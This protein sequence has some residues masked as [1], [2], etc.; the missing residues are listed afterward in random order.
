MRVCLSKSSRNGWPGD[1]GFVSHGLVEEKG[2][3]DML[4]R[5]RVK[6]RDSFSVQKPSVFDLGV[7]LQVG[8]HHIKREFERT[9]I[10][11]SE[12]RRDVG[13]VTCTRGRLRGKPVLL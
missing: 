1:S 7:H 13:K 9:R 3:N 10:L 11:A 5:D 12:D 8:E 6:L 4:V 2:S